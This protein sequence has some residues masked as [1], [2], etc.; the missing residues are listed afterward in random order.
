MHL[1]SSC[2]SCSF[3]S[4]RKIRLNPESLSTTNITTSTYRRYDYL[5]VK[6]LLN[7]NAEIAVGEVII[8]DNCLCVWYFYFLHFIVV[9]V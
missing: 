6:N 2:R 3:R 5:L 1:E 7:N 4:F 8:A 9:L